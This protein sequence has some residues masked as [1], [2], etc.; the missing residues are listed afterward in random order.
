M[1]RSAFLASLFASLLLGCS[2]GDRA[3]AAASARLPAGVVARVGSLDVTSTLVAKLASGAAVPPHEARERAIRDAIFAAGAQA[4]GHDALPEV[5]SA[6]RGRLARARLRELA[7]EA[8]SAPL[9]DAEVAEATARHFIDFDRPESFRTTHALVKLPASSDA[10]TRARVRALAERI[11]REVATAAAP[12]EFRGRALAVDHPDLEVVV[13]DLAPV[14]ADGR[15]LD[16]ARP[17]GPNGEVGT[18]VEPYARAAAALARPGDISPVVETS[19]GLHV[20]LLT[21]R[22]AAHIVPLEERRARLRDEILDGRA[23]RAADEHVKRLRAAVGPA[24]DRS[25]AE[26]LREVRVEDP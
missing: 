8:R 10:A 21:E 25:A 13:E 14:A 4:R 7:A 1:V 17:P 6:V 19:F 22:V 26:L 23:R 20:I 5:R 11:A 18:L 3:P 9:T 2:A 12:A 16:P 15:L 24:A